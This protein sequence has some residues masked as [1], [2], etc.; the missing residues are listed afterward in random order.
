MRMRNIWF[1]G[2]SFLVA[3]LMVGYIVFSI[4]D[5]MRIDDADIIGTVIAC[6]IF[7]LFAIFYF[8]MSL[9]V[10]DMQRRRRKLLRSNKKNT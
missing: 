6:V 4:M 7:L 8:L 9:R 10:G 2:L 5:Y 1:D 3:V